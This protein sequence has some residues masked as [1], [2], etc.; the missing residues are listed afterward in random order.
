[1][2][3]AKRRADRKYS[4][5]HY[6]RIAIRVRLGVRQQWHDLAELHGLSLAGLIV[7]AVQEFAENHRTDSPKLP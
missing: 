4:D 1:M 6:D 5:S 3:D 2:T 7:Q